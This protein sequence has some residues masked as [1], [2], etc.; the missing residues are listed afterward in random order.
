MEKQPYQERAE[1]ELPWPPPKGRRDVRKKKKPIRIDM[2]PM[3]DMAFLL[4]T[5]FMLATT[6]SRPQVMELVMPVPPEKEDAEQEQPVKESRALT[7]VLADNDRVVWFRGITDPDVHATDFSEDGIRS[8]LR[9]MQE[10]VEDPII[11]I[12]PLPD[13]RYENLIDLLD[14]IQTLGLQRYAISELQERDRAILE[15]LE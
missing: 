15:R 14:E 11:L 13:S 3:V 1:E 2:N 6:F 8:V 5:F 7:I 10:E 12:K 4:L 9:Q